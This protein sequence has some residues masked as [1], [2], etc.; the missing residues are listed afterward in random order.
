MAWDP[1]PGP[2]IPELFSGPHSGTFFCKVF[3]AFPGNSS[4]NVDPADPTKF[5]TFPEKSTK[6][7][8]KKPDLA[9]LAKVPESAGLAGRSRPRLASPSNVL[10]QT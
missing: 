4:N 3:V 10:A 6:N 5:V 7:V 2:Q 1:Y 9:F 8:D